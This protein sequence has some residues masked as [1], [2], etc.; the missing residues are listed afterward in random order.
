MDVLPCKHLS[1]LFELLQKHF[2]GWDWDLDAAKEVQPLLAA[3]KYDAAMS[4]FYD[5]KH[6][7]Q[8]LA[9]KVL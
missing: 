9:S 7:S 8:S 6:V 1:E 4:H 5:S 3:E 2:P